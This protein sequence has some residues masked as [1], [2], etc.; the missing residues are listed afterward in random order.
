[1]VEGIPVYK[2]LHVIW[3]WWVW[4]WEGN[5]NIVPVGNQGGLSS[6]GR[7]YKTL[8]GKKYYSLKVV[9]IKKNNDD[10]EASNLVGLMYVQPDK[11]Y[12]LPAGSLI[13]FYHN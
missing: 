7:K 2:L 11:C 9:F 6:L 12:P 5:Y 1:M 8:V 4:S 3:G 13:S 10:K